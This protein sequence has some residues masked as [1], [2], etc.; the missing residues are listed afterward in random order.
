MF[1]NI[2]QISLQLSIYFPEYIIL[3]IIYPQKLVSNS[4]NIDLK[5]SDK[6]ERFQEGEILKLLLVLTNRND[7][8]SACFLFIKTITFIKKIFF[9]TNCILYP[10][11]WDD[12]FL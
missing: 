10:F 4:I 2:K 7:Y 9:L 5:I 11:F 6:L 12:Y 8:F 1:G 3:I